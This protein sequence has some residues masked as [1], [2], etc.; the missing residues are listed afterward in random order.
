MMNSREAVEH[1][2]APKEISPA[3]ATPVMI[4]ESFLALSLPEQPSSS[5]HS[6]WVGS[7]VPPPWL[8]TMSDGMVREK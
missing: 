6:R 2:A 8:A 3:R 7:P 5:R 1:S 4:S